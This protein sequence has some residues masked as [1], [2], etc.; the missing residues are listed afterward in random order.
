VND[1]TYPTTVQSHDTTTRAYRWLM[2]KESI[3][4]VLAIAAWIWWALVLLGL[5][6]ACLVG[7][8]FFIEI[9]MRLARGQ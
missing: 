5:A 4:D 3:G 7:A 6:A 8:G 9:G 2:F 1:P